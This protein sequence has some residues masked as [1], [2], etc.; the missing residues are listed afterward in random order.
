M[1]RPR[2]SVVACA[3]LAAACKRTG[4]RPAG[5]PPP[6][7]IPRASV[8]FALDGELHEAPWNERSFRAVLA[9]AGEEARPYSE[10]RLLHDAQNLYVGLYAADED[11]H[12][13]DRW[14]LAVG[15]RT[16]H[17]D[18]AGRCDQPDVK[19]GVDRDG[20]IDQPGDFDEE[21]V[22]EAAIPL[23]TLGPAPLPIAAR[24]CDTLKSG[25]HRCG[26]WKR[27]LGLE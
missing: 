14:E 2:S 12:A 20:T 5:P 4:D 21:W 15:P 27:T 7:T 3:L 19:A 13:T 8:A 23:A 17:F 24:R 16:L 9:D 11:I 6:D 22:I 26:A 10:L 25:E 1:A 18:A